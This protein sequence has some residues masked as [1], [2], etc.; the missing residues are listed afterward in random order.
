MNAVEAVIFD[1]SG[2]VVD[3]GSR[4]P[5]AAFVEVF[6]E[7]GIELTVAEARGPMGLPKRDHIRK[8]GDLPRV[9]AVWRKV[10]GRAFDEADV[11][12]I[13]DCFEPL[14][15]RVAADHARLVPGAAQVAAELRRRGI[16]IGSTTGYTRPIMESVLPLAARQG[17]APDNLVCAGDLPAGRPTPLMMYRC[18]V[19]LAVWPA[20]AV[21]KVDDT[22]PGIEEATAAG[23]WAI[24]VAMSGNAVGPLAG[25]ACGPRS[26]RDGAPARAGDG[27]ASRRRRPLRHRHRRG[28]PARRRSNRRAARDRRHPRLK[29]GTEGR[30]RRGRCSRPGSA[31]E[32]PRRR[33]GAAQH[34]HRAIRRAMIVGA[35]S[36]RQG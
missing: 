26:G 8:L 12:R 30:S 18:F 2:T 4:A 32:P 25:R 6:R 33:R 11:D 31:P 34:R 16:R 20:A 13:H 21:V 5:A 10:H 29:G 19:D 24:G 35:G 15:A 27:G 14:T 9:A 3:F 1:W 28:P 7:F 22:A 36:A 23:S 17:F